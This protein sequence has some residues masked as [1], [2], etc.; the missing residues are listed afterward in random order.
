[1]DFSNHEAEVARAMIVSAINLRVLV[2]HSK[3]NR[4][5]SF[6]LCPLADIDQLVVDK[7]P[8]A[9]LLGA[10]ETSGVEVI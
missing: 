1:M 5:A 2:D 6:R 10:L 8:D 4:S 9:D 3:F 7:S